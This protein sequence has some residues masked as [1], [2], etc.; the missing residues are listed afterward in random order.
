MA[1]KVSNL[2]SCIVDA[3]FDFILDTLNAP[4]YYFLWWIKYLLYEKVG[5]ATYAE[6]WSVIVFILS[7]FYGLLL[8]Y[9][10]LKFIISGETP[11]QRENAKSSLKN[12]LIMIILVQASYHI[13]SLILELFNA[14]NRSVFNLIDGNFFLV[15][16]DNFINIGF[17]LAVLTPYLLILVMTLVILIIRY[18]IVSAGVV[19]FAIGIFFYFI[20]FLN[21][22]GKMIINGLI[23]TI[24]LPFFYSIILL[25]SSKLTSIGHF[26][27]IK[28]VISLAAFFS[29]NLFTL[30]LVLFV[31]IKAAS[32]LSGPISTIAKVVN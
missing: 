27:N 1:C 22:Y 5:I 8:V 13:Y 17:S 23:V 29:L 21:S 6:I 15:N 28:T 9:I 14:L 3:F 16:G 31:V 10:G 11:E 7:L 19:L 20:P 24:S 32:N 4:I 18:I 2:G 12:T 26:T 30:L 25:F